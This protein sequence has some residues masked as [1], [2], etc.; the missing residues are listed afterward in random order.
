MMAAPAYALTIARAAQILHENEQLLRD[1]ALGMEPEDGR[2]WIYGT[3]QQEMLAFTDRGMDCLRE[4][5][6][7]Y[8]CSDTRS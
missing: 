4:L 2:L 6:A 3:D 5:I 7:E 1:L 8:R